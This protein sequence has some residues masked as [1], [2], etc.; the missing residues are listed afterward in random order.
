MPAKAGI[1]LRAA[2]DTGFR[3]CD[4]EEQTDVCPDQGLR[5]GDGR[6]NGTRCT[7]T[8]S[9]PAGN[10]PDDFRQLTAPAAACYVDGE[11]TQGA[12][13]LRPSSSH[14]DQFHTQRARPE[15]QAAWADS[16]ERSDASQAPVIT[17]QRQSCA[18]GF[19][20]NNWHFKAWNWPASSSLYLDDYY[21]STGFRDCFD[22]KNTGAW[23]HN[24]YQA[25]PHY[26]DMSWRFNV[27]NGPQYFVQRVYAPSSTSPTSTRTSSTGW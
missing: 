25:V 1:Q 27:D 18:Q 23:I 16:G 5:R 22:S 2:L 11:D 7:V 10:A 14:S 24:A 13:S 19:G 3:R 9:P 4:S 15:A 20:S 21:E 6:A 12:A 26:D 8:N 17:R